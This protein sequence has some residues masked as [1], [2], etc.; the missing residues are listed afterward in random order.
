MLI[1]ESSLRYHE[2]EGGQGVGVARSDCWN[3]RGAGNDRIALTEPNISARCF[4]NLRVSYYLPP[5]TVVVHV[6]LIFA[7][8]RQTSSLGRR[9]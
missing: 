9:I 1:A 7:I 3:I 2:A 4:S 8:N 5:Q 6:A